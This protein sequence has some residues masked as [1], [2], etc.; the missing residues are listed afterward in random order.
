MSRNYKYYLPFIF[1]GLMWALVLG[2]DCMGDDDPP[3]GNATY[4]VSPAGDNSAD[5]LS[6]K[7]AFQTIGHALDILLAGETVIILSGTYNEGLRLENR[8]SADASI[9]IKGENGT[10]MLDG[11]ESMKAAFWISESVNIIIDNLEIANY[12]DAG[13][14]VTNSADITIKNIVAHDNGKAAVSLWAEGYGIHADDSINVTIENND[15]YN[16]G[17]QPQIPSKLMGTGINCFNI[18][19]S[20]IRGNLSHHNVGGGILVEDS[21]NVLVEDNEAQYNDLDASVD[22]WWDGGIWVDGGHDITVRNNLFSNNKGPGIEIS[23]ED[24]QEPYGYIFENNISTNNYYGIYI[25]NFGTSDYPSEDILKM[26]NNQITGN[27]IQDTWIVP[28]N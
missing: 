28:W 19:D 17:P 25:W 14:V 8:G 5:G 26:E 10:S 15:A 22:E 27:T 20:V 16:N 9:T 3:V 6:R 7:S 4:Y 13:I 11:E 12:T 2:C 23:D 1:L 21:V 24:F 18:Q